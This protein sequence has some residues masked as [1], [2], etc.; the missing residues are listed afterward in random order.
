V[1]PE[2]DLVICRTIVGINNCEEEDQTKYRKSS[3]D[4]HLNAESCEDEDFTS[5]AIK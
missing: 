1:K 5:F 2:I 3:L 4:S